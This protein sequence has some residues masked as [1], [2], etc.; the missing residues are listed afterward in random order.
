MENNRS[1]IELLKIVLDNVN[2]VESIGIGGL[3]SL[4]DELYL[5]DYINTDELDMLSIYMGDNIPVDK[6]WCDY[7]WPKYEVKPRKEW[8]E[9]QIKLLENTAN[10]DN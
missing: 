8:L 9:N 7:W 10:H 6:S 5:D 4:I 3:C 2:S 1:I